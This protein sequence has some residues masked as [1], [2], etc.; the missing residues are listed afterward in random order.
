[1]DRYQRIL[2]L[3]RTLRNARYPVSAQQLMDELECSRATVYRDVAMLRDALG[4]PIV[5]GGDDHPGFAY[6][7]NQI[8][9]YELPGLWLN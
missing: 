9:L 2:T 6:D 1:M 8:E 3:H 7:R 5:G 4:A